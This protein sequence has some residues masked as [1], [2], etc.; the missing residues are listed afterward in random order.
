MLHMQLKDVV[1]IYHSNQLMFSA[2]TKSLKRVYFSTSSV[3]NDKSKFEDQQFWSC[4]QPK[5]GF[6][7]MVQS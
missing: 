4:S 1:Y 3:I 2:F 7:N 5:K 6:L